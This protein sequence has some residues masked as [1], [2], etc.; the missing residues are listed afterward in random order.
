ML[1]SGVAVWA[2]KGLV[3]WISEQIKER[4]KEYT[5]QF[6]GSGVGKAWSG[7]GDYVALSV[8]R[9]KLQDNSQPKLTHHAIFVIPP[10]RQDIGIYQLEPLYWNVTESAPARS[11]SEEFTAVINVRLSGYWSLSGAPQKE[12]IAEFAWLLNK[13]K[14]G[15]PL[16]YTAANKNRIAGAETAPPS[17][18]F[19]LPKSDAVL[20]ASFTVAEVDASN[21]KKYLELLA[22]AVGKQADAVGGLVEDQFK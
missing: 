19:G 9:W 2:A 16:L 8:R 21:A 20:Y 14:V 1:A 3:S 11:R 17:A 5:A 15:H 18:P 10:V 22:D 6:G 7:K 12:S 13:Y 4:A